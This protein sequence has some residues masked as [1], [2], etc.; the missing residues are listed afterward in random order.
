MGGVDYDP[1]G[2]ARSSTNTGSLRT[3]C[4]RF[5]RNAPRIGCRGLPRQAAAETLEQALARAYTN[6]PQLNAQR[7]IVRQADEGVPQALSGYRPNVSANASVGRQYTD[8]KQTIPPTPPLAPASATIAAQGLSTPRSV[9]AIAQHDKVVASYSLLSA[10]GRLS[11]Q[12]LGLPVPIYDPMVH[13]QQVRD[14]WIGLRTPRGINRV[15]ASNSAIE[16]RSRL[17][18]SEVHR[19][20]AF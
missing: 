16:P 17:L 6:N 7:A 12:V 2:A 1:A 13:Y 8:I 3:W 10:V 19:R 9:G 14:S 15:I 4:R 11:P 5:H 20:E 18:T